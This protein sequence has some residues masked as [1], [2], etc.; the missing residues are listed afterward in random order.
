MR[1]HRSIL[2]FLAFVI[3]G[4]IAA[5][6]V[7]ASQ[8]MDFDGFLK[9]DGISEEIPVKG[10][11]WGTRKAASIGQFDTNVPTASTRSFSIVTE[12]GIVSNVLSEAVK[13]NKSFALAV[14]VIRK[15]GKIINEFKL[16]ELTVAKIKTTGS[17]EEVTFNFPKGKFK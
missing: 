3:L 9:I 1:I 6:P 2:V 7:Q 15:G 13:T 8:R 5:E 12:K 4:F 10:F 11:S 16:F 14:L 17:F